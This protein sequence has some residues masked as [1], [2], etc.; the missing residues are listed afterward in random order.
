[1]VSHYTNWSFSL[2]GNEKKLLSI[3]NKKPRERSPEEKQILKGLESDIKMIKKCDRFVCVAQH[4]LD[5]LL[6]IS[7]IDIS[8]CRIINNALK[9]EYKNIGREK[10]QTLRAK[11]W[12]PLNTKII[13]FVGRLDEVKGVAFLI[14]AF[15]KLLQTNSDTHLIVAGDG[16]YSRWLKEAGNCWTKITFTGRLGKK[17]IFELY[18]IADV[19]VVTS[20]HEE[21]G[22]VAIEMMMH[23]LPIVTT[24]TG[25]L[26]EIIED[27][28]SGLKV[29]VQI[30][31]G[32]RIIDTNKLANKISVL[33]YDTDLA[34]RIAKN[35]RARYLEKYE[36]SVLKKNMLNLYNTI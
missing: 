30:K 26:S 28:I 34:E 19:G 31:E 33:L 13:L 1:L 16:D 11:W 17:K 10:K 2:F 22:Y 9:D 7:D 12:M 24:D 18:Q 8:K 36:L 29:P 32:K 27:N 35:G 14:K 4:T 20:L 6:K 15:K 21:F 5:T 3:A 23:R 25:G